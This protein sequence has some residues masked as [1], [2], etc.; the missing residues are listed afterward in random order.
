MFKNKKTTYFLI[1]VILLRT[2]NTYAAGGTSYSIGRGILKF[3]FYVLAIFAVII[4]TIYGTRFIA[5][6]SKKYINSKYIVLLDRIIVDTNSKILLIEVNNY[7]YLLAM[8]PNDIEVIDKVPMEDFEKLKFERQLE[9]EKD[10]YLQSRG[11][12]FSTRN[13]EKFID[14]LDKFFNKEDKN[15]DE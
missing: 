10:K 3:V 7:I 11:S 2:S 1:I 8:N 6:S 4:I 14:R 13:L 5:Q 15:N 9:I 12:K